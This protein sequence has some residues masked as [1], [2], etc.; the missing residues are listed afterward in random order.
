V[1]SRLVD[2]AELTWYWPLY[3]APSWR[4]LREVLSLNLEAALPMRYGPGDPPRYAGAPGQPTFAQEWERLIGVEW[5]AI[6]EWR[7]RPPVFACTMMWPD[8]R[9]S[10]P[11]LVAS[12]AIRLDAQVDNGRG[13]HESLLATIGIATDG[14]FACTYT[15]RN[16]RVRGGA[17]FANVHDSD[18]SPLPR[19]GRWLG[20]PPD[21]PECAWFGRDYLPALKADV[22]GFQPETG[23]ACPRGSWPESVQDL[24]ARRRDPRFPGVPPSEPAQLIPALL[25]S[26]RA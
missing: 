15:L 21:A 24:C 9:S 13:G 8:A 17:L 7:G 22:E 14:L 10:D 6:L 16:W 20:L 1:N 12:L 25:P 11:R 18:Q 4:E 19:G 2:V 23:V 3:R 26:M 5:G